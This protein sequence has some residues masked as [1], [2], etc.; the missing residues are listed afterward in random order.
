MNDMN[1]LEGPVVKLDE[2]LV[3]LI[4]INIGGAA[5][6]DSS[7]CFAALQDEHLTVVLPE[8]L[9][10]LLRLEEGDRISVLNSGG[11]FNIRPVNPRVNWSKS[12]GKEELEQ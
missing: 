8:W 7:R 1:C 10:T 9:V 6:T 3:L 12:F 11:R 4:P 2:Q 5:V